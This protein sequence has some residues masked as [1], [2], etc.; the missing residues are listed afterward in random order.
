ME[1]LLLALTM[2]LLGMAVSAVLFAAATRDERAEEA[3]AAAKD[4]AV[5]PSEFFA[6]NPPL[7]S[8]PV[9]VEVLLMQIER[10]VKA[11]KHAAESFSSS[12]TLEALRVETS[13]PLVR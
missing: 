4:L 8:P 10:H 7:E 6:E 2:S 1:M 5:A 9:S 11:E 12:P 13:S 3:E